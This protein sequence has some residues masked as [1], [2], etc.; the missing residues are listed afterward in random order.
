MPA[1][2]A[3]PVDH[4]GINVT[5]LDRSVRF[6]TDVFGVDV[7][8]TDR[9]RG[10]ALLGHDGA[11][12]LTLWQQAADGFDAKRA[13]FH[14]LAFTAAHLDDVVAAEERLRSRGVEP[15]HGGI[16]PQAAGLPGG[17]LYFLDPDGIRLEI[18]AS[19]GGHVD[20]EPPFGEA[21]TCGF[22]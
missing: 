12:R 13:G 22:F 15:L 1:I 17:A 4:V 18:A 9:E 10:F 14:H 20:A 5:D 6:Y 19:D 11:I 3:P 2:T 21:P 16:V 7:I 8:A